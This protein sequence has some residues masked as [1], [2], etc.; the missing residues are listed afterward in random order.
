[1]PYAR[2]PKNSTLVKDEKL[3]EIVKVIMQLDLGQDYR[4]PF[5]D[6]EEMLMMERKIRAILSSYGRKEDF[7]LRRRNNFVLV[8]DTKEEDNITIKEETI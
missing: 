4:V 6:E 5:E 2:N 7:K 1:M 8:I 3:M